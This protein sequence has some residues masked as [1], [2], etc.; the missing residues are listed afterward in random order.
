L[1]S[2]EFITSQWVVLCLAYEN[3]HILLLLS[4]N[5]AGFQREGKDY[6]PEG[7]FKKSHGE[8]P[9]SKWYA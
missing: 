3:K 5:F 7:Y 1:F 4:L 8:I 9:C 6:M 2:I